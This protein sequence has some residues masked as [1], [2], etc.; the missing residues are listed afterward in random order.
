MVNI[1]GSVFQYHHLYQELKQFSKTGEY[2]CKELMTVFQQRCT[3]EPTPTGS[4]QPGFTSYC[5][6]ATLKHMKGRS[7]LIVSCCHCRSLGNAF[8]Q[9]A[10]LELRQV[11]DEHNKRKRPLDSVIER[12]GKLVTANWSEQLKMK[13]K[14]VGIT[15]EHEALFNFVENNKQMCTEKEKQKMLNRLTKSAEVQARVDEEYFNINMEGHQMRL[16]WENTLKNCY[17]IIQ[18][19]EKQRIELQCNILSR[20]NLHMSSFG[21]TLKHGQKQIEQTIQRVDMDRDIETLLTENSITADNSKAEFLMADYFEEDS[22]SLMYKD[23]RKEAIKLK[24]QRLD[25]S[26][27][28]AKKDCEGIERLMKTYSENPSFSNH[29]NLEETEQQLDETTLKLDLLEAT[30][31]KLSLSLAELEGRPKSIHRFSD[32]I[33][34]WK[35]KDCEHSIVQLTRPVKFRRT[36]FRS[37]LRA[38]IIYKGPPQIVA[39]QSVEPPASVTS[40]VSTHQDVGAESGSI[41][42]GMHK[43]LFPTL[44]GQCKAIY[45]FTPEQD[46]ELTLKEGDLLNIYTKEE[47]GWWFGELNGRT[48]HFPSTYVE[49][50]PVIGSVKC[51]DA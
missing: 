44:I 14:L 13:K 31:Y 10:I 6:C 18:E 27:T 48:G 16:K 28:K 23:R 30:H 46:D 36:P 37:R 9:E 5:A 4:F 45:D 19:L 43:N 8:Q 17:Q 22:K 42:N 32:S 50:L 26:I 21:Q 7:E 35:D 40:T 1:F 2:F 34:K 47:N 39:Q 3:Q 11:L 24:I 25:D 51:S 29:K 49:E 15:R 33:M 20:Y 41:V 12:T 38:S